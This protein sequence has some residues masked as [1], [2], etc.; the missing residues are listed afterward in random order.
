MAKKRKIPVKMVAK[1]PETSDLDSPYI[2]PIKSFKDYTTDNIKSIII[3]S[4][5]AQLLILIT[6]VGCFL[7]FYNLAFNSLWLDETSSVTI[8]MLGSYANILNYTAT[9]E[10][11]PPLFVWIV[12]TMMTLFG[13]NEFI[14]RF[15]S[16]FFGSLT[17]PV[18]YFVGKEF[19]DRNGGIIAAAACALS[20]FLI[21]YSQEARAY[22]MLLF[23]IALALLFYFRAIK[24]NDYNYW[25]LF[26]I[27]TIF[28]FWTHFYSIIFIGTLFIYTLAIYKLKYI[29]ELIVSSIIMIIGI[30]PLAII[31][32][33]TILKYTTDTPSFGIQG[34]NVITVSL[35]QFT[36]NN[37]VLTYITGLL[38]ICGISALYIKE[39]EKSLLIILILVCAFITSIY[40]SYRIPIVPR[41]LSFINVAL[42]LGVAASYKLFYALTHQKIVIY[43]LILLMVCFITPFLINY[44]SAYSK[45]DWRGFSKTLTT[46]TQPGD[47]III[48]PGYIS[49]PLNYYYSNET[50]KTIEYFAYNESQLSTA[51]SLQT[52]VSYYVVTGDIQSANQNGDALKWLESNTKQAYQNGGIYLFRS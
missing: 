3:N 18:M 47:S 26:A 49:Q 8:A 36:G 1:F 10:P 48:V 25:I 41:Y 52:G 51:R 5:Y 45:D 50:D 32:I 30:L 44:Y 38:F 40:F 24:E 17:V 9:M 6:L 22:A 43:I 37:I 19:I 11:N 13:N 23:F 16:A 2:N 35:I 34:L 21:L 20:P 33:P 14:I 4:R 31:A 46:M 12:Y 7:R 28:V 29:K 39:K 27:A 42:I 15:A